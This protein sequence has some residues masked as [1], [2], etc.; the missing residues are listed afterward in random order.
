MDGADDA[1]DVGSDVAAKVMSVSN[2]CALV[3]RFTWY[4][5]SNF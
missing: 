3:Y 5:C 2:K 1:S 4:H